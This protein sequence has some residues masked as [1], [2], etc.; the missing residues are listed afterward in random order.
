MV[1]N[2]SGRFEMMIPGGGEGGQNQPQ[3]RT[4]EV[5]QAVP[6]P[7]WLVRVCV[8]E[9]GPVKVLCI[10]FPTFQKVLN[11]LKVKE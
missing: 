7:G 1:R 5:T 9:E 2:V 4:A 3:L 8:Q 10:T 6:T 11:I